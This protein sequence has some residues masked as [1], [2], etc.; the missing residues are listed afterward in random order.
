MIQQ[1]IQTNTERYLM[2]LSGIQYMRAPT[3]VYATE[4]LGFR[5]PQLDSIPIRKGIR[6]YKRQQKMRLSVDRPMPR[7]T[8]RSTGPKPRAACFQSVDRAVDRFMPRSTGRSTDILLCTLCTPVDCPIDRFLL[9]SIER[10]TKVI[11]GLLH[12]PFLTSFVF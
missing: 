9:R 6:I 1:S 11:L 2:E 8:V 4:S 10:S 3:L 12:V 7:S 5:K